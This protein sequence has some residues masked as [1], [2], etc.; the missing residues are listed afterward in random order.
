MAK[1][2]AHTNQ[3]K[4][5][6]RRILVTVKRDM[7]EVTPRAIWE[8]EKPILEAM[9]EEGNIVVVPSETLDE[10]Y[11][12]RPRPDLLIH[13][14]VQDMIM[15]PSECLGLGFVFIG[16][17]DVEYQ[18]LGAVYGRLPDENR[19]FVEHIYGRAQEKRFASL[20]GAPDLDD[21]PESQLRQIVLDYGY[22]PIPHKDASA[23]EKNEV[24]KM[25]KELADM[26]TADL[27][28]L[29]QSLGVQ[30]G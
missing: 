28:A 23:D 29:A 8:H 9:F 3:G 19:L 7:T 5:L 13:N 17:P 25:R 11:T 22:A 12:P 20:L 26:K 15:R 4:Q 14:K 10:G 16:N 18:R 1:N 27:V 6:S 21:L 30:I 2:T 24:F